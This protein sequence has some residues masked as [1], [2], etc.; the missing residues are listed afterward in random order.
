M[1]KEGENME[2]LRVNL[3]PIISGLN[4]PTAIKTTIM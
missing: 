3:R 4:L 1:N 2:N